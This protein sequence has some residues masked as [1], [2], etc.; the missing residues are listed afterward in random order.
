MS[1]IN[2]TVDLINK[3]SVMRL[4]R[5]SEVYEIL[6]NDTLEKLV[7]EQV[8][9]LVGGYQYKQHHYEITCLVTFHQET[10]TWIGHFFVCCITKNMDMEETNSILVFRDRSA[11]FSI[12]LPE[13][14]CWNKDE[15]MIHTTIYGEKFPTSMFIK[16][17]TKRLVNNTVVNLRGYP[18]EGDF[19]KEG[20]GYLLNQYKFDIS[21]ELKVTIDSFGGVFLKVKTPGIK[22]KTMVKTIPLINK[23]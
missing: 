3:G 2:K 7:T 22:A 16:L 21:E 17:L 13:N 20:K 12:S 6:T 23:G 14:L 15:Q 9:T 5:L 1:N 8:I 10:E 4:G 18:L 19:Q 11:R